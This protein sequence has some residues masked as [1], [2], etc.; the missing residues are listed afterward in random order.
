MTASLDE[1]LGAP[2]KPSLDSILGAPAKPQLSEAAQNGEPWATVGGNVTGGQIDNRQV[3]GFVKKLDMLNTAVDNGVKQFTTTILSA[4]PFGQ[5]WKNALKQVYNNSEAEQQHNIDTYKGYYPQIGKI[6][7]ETLVTAPVGGVLGKVLGKAVSLGAGEAI[8]P[9]GILGSTLAKKA[10][11]GILQ[12]PAKYALAG[13]AGVGTNMAMESQRYDPEHPGQLINTKAAKSV[14]DNPTSTLLSAGL[15]M[16]GA[17]A[18]SYAQKASKIGEY[19]DILGQTAIPRN[20]L[21]DSIGKTFKQSVFGFLPALTSSGA[22]ITEHK[23]IGEP[24]WNFISKFADAPEAKN[25]A[26]INAKAGQVLKTALGNLK[27][28][29]QDLWNQPFKSR[30]LSAEDTS[31]AVADATQALKTIGDVSQAIPSA[32]LY[33]KLISRQLDKVGSS[34][35][36]LLDASGNAIS[37]AGK[38]T[39]EDVKNIQSNLG[40]A[41]SKIKSE[42]GSNELVQELSGIHDQLGTRIQNSLSADDLAAFMA[43]K[44]HSR[45]LYDLKETSPLVKDAMVNEFEAR[46]LLEKL[47]STKEPIDKQ[48]IFDQIGPEGQKAVASEKLAEAFRASNKS[49]GLDIDGFLTRTKNDPELAS[50]MGNDAFKSFQGLSAYIKN[51][52]EGSKVG[53]WK[54][55]AIMTAVG[56]PAYL[57]GAGPI[58]G[59]GA[60]ASLAAATFAANHPAL[61]NL[62]YGLSRK[63]P[64]DTKNL[65]Q[66]AIGNHLNRAGYFIG[67][68]GVLKHKDENSNAN[69]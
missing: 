11:P 47:R 45:M 17:A 63:L 29:N 9:S 35:S 31:G 28:T 42:A 46:K 44:Q 1:I 5:G 30:V 26:D 40:K 69:N 65:I 43:A 8:A 50:L 41:I 59:A 64:E 21:P 13:A 58:A 66:K 19:S 27:Q 52:S 24:V 6:A 16:F 39:V 32:G 55:A 62:F 25:F 38:F 22:A 18:G 51:V 61:K 60:V 67:T 20:T 12:T 33:T 48:K 37:K 10:L 15:P 7:G 57:S 2:Q 23:N 56:I 53:W 36:A 14:I 68:D 4:L 3:P 34:D 49:D 54:P